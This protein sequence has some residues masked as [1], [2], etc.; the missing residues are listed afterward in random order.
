MIE[1][2]ELLLGLT[3]FVGAF[4]VAWA[5]AWYLIRHLDKI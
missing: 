5:G 3:L 2:G 1:T 4:A